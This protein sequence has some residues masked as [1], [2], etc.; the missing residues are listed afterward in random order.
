MYK[1]ALSP[2]RLKRAQDIVGEVIIRARE[3][4]NGDVI[5]LR[6]LL[7]ERAGKE[8]AFRAALVRM[9]LAVGQVSIA[10]DREDVRVLGG[11]NDPWLII[12]DADDSH[13]STM[14]AAHHPLSRNK[15]AAAGEV[16]ASAMLRAD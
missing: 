12:T 10:C 1:D 4:A 3:D 15:R 2:T 5:R 13:V 8:T 14:I 7:W 16:L 11:I 9:V 6:M